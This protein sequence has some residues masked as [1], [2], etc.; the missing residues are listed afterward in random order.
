M[1]ALSS[2]NSAASPSSTVAR[3][4]TGMIQAASGAFPRTLSCITICSV[5]PS[6]PTADVSRA[7]STRL[8]RFTTIAPQPQA[9]AGAISD[10]S[11]NDTNI[12][13][14]ESARTAQLLAP[15]SLPARRIFRPPRRY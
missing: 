9:Y 7:T 4:G 6:Q 14:R 13:A 3:C 5:L 10:P 2:V 15:R 8:S 11:C 1:I 12:R